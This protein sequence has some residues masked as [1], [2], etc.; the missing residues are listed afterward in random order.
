LALLAARFAPRPP[1]GADAETGKQRPCSA[2]PDN[3]TSELRFTD[4]GL[5]VIAGDVVVHDWRAGKVAQRYPD[6]RAVSFEGFALSADRRL[7][8]VSE[9][10]G[11]IRLLDAA[12]G[13]VVRTLKGHNVLAAPP[14]RA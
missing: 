11:A 4:R 13:K 6:P 10:G 9:L 14:R 2:D 12:S 3:Y 7:M 8:A 1:K 5:L